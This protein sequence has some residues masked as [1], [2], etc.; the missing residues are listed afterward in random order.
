MCCSN[1][2]TLRTFRGLRP[3]LRLYAHCQTSRSLIDVMSKCLLSKRLQ[4]SNHPV[5]YYHKQEISQILDTPKVAKLHGVL[6]LE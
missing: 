4:Q 2:S 6:Q 3:G 5:H 1:S